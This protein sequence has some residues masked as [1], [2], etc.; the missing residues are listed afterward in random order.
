MTFFQA[1]FPTEALIISI[2]GFVLTFDQKMSLEIAEFMQLFR[3]KR[4]EVRNT[5][6]PWRRWNPSLLNHLYS[7]VSLA[8]T[9]FH[10]YFYAKPKRAG[11]C[12]QP[13][14]P[15]CPIV[16]AK[17]SSLMKN[18][19]PHILWNSETF[20]KTFHSTLGVNHFPNKFLSLGG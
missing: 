5:K 6:Q 7:I 3:E 19:E 2:K 10:P 16:P 17:A 1:L 8:I 12:S 20:E 9:R 14:N 18:L 13:S 11:H 15:T 4:L